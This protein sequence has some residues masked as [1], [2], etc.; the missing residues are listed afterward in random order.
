MI[1]RERSALTDDTKA[2]G[3]ISLATEKGKRG[4]D[5]KVYQETLKYILN[6]GIIIGTIFSGI[7]IVRHLS[8]KYISFM[9]MKLFGVI[10][11]IRDG[12]NDLV[13]KAG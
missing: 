8:L 13:V 5:K 9:P 7:M 1:K 2:Q 3:R 11:K 10:F 12:M 4:N 6:A